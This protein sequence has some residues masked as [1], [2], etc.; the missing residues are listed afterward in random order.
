MEF[1]GVLAIFLSLSIP[2][3]AIVGGVIATISRKKRETELRKIM[4]ENNV[5][6][7]RIKLLVEEPDKK[8]NK[9]VMLRWGCILAFGGLATIVYY[10]VNSNADPSDMLFWFFLAIG[11]GIGMLVSFMIEMRITKKEKEKAVEEQS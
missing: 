7:E 5:D 2:I 9:F 1:E 4:V 8:I 6:A 11:M 10:F 3:V